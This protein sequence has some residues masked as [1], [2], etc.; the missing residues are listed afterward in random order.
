MLAVRGWEK[1]GTMVLK[2]MCDNPSLR[3]SYEIYD[4][5]YISRASYLRSRILCR[6]PIVQNNLRSER[7]RPKPTLGS[8]YTGQ[9][10]QPCTTRH[11]NLVRVPTHT[12]CDN[13]RADAKIKNLSMQDR[14]V[15]YRGHIIVS[16]R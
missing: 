6:Q 9:I 4:N 16:V 7:I 3:Y 15:R 1:R 12:C 8:R 11:Q 10:N 14:I 5:L 2:V 13:E